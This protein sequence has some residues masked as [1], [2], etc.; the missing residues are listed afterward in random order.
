MASKKQK[1]YKAS[2][3]Q[4][5]RKD[6]SAE[7]PS[8]RCFIW[9]FVLLYIGLMGLFL[10]LI[11][12]QSIKD[13]FDING[14]YTHMIIWLSSTALK[15]FGIV[16]DT[17]GTII[18]LSGINLDVRFGCNGLEAFLIYLA[19]I[20]AFPSSMRLK[21]FGVIGGFVVLQLLN[22]FRIAGLGLS[23]VYLEKYFYIIHTYVAQGIMI[24]FALIIYLI[25]LHY[26]SER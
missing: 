15:P 5:V 6:A 11:G 26:A 21:L 19:A 20:I 14:L 13:F 22:V 12:L 8:G 16:N 9:K 10:V 2:K 7:S 4:L 24:V 25:W 1:K 17:S 23:G 18:A 3:K